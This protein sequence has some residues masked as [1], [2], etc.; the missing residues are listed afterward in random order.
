MNAFSDLTAQVSRLEAVSTSVLGANEVGTVSLEEPNGPLDELYFR[1]LVAWCY[2]LLYETGVFFRFSRNLL[3]GRDANG[4]QHL[5]YSGDIVRCARTVHSHNLRD[6]RSSDH[7][8][9]TKYTTWL[10]AEG[11]E[12]VDW[13]RCI[14]AMVAMVRKSLRSV[15]QA[16]EH[17][18]SGQCPGENLADSYYLEKEN[19][20]EAHEFDRCV[21]SAANAI[22]LTGLDCVKFRESEGRL[23]KWRRLIGF[24]YTREDARKAVERAIQRELF[25]LFGDRSA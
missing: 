22:G 5:S 11:G 23:D 16:W 2:A 25:G 4:L 1:K 7:R 3:R 18:G 10:L 8:T 14:G 19:H 12:P 20:W 21:V 24:F 17:A 13:G 9:R 15:E 6:D